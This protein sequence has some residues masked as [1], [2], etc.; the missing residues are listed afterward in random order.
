[1]SN[2][3]QP[4]SLHCTLDSEISGKARSFALTFSHDDPEDCSKSYARILTSVVHLSDLIACTF[5][6][7]TCT[8][9]FLL[10]QM[11]DAGFYD[12]YK[13]TEYELNNKITQ[14]HTELHNIA[15]SVYNLRDHYNSATRDFLKLNEVM[16]AQFQSEIIL[17]GACRRA[18]PHQV[19]IC[20]F[21]FML[22]RALNVQKPRQILIYVRNRLMWW[23]SSD[24]ITNIYGNPT[25]L[26]IMGSAGR[27]R[28]LKM[29]CAQINILVLNQT[30]IDN[31]FADISRA[32]LDCIHI[33]LT[34]LCP[35]Y[36][37]EDADASEFYHHFVYTMGMHCGIKRK[38]IFPKSEGMIDTIKTKINPVVTGLLFGTVTKPK[39]P[40]F[41]IT[42][43]EQP[44]NDYTPHDIETFRI[45][46]AHQTKEK[47]VS[48]P[49]VYCQIFSMN[50][51]LYIL[52][53]S[54][55]SIHKKH[56]RTISDLANAGTNSVQYRKLL[57]PIHNK[58]EVGTTNPLKNFI[59]SLTKENRELS[60]LLFHQYRVSPWLAFTIGSLRGAMQE[61]NPIKRSTKNNRRA[62]NAIMKEMDQDTKELLGSFQKLRAT[63]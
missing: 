37:G 46:K 49:P 2:Q 24:N 45:L 1:M 55:M 62:R 21:A 17:E 18:L 19:A 44:D 14:M 20:N 10:H 48:V 8:Y 11:K 40:R 13:L 33:I 60:L 28:S 53:P 35:V 50:A 36:A 16:N 39:H 51:L 3:P 27:K 57:I 26:R 30:P 59:D 52:R 47:T 4:Q 42:P 54:F 29:L 63:T 15:T 38:F 23:A 58:L 7:K 31:A 5:D 12:I 32:L 9:G 56:G 22:C 43:S 6:P 25:L 61:S 34:E 41:L